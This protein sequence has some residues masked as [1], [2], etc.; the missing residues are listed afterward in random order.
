ML[1]SGRKKNYSD[2][3][4]VTIVGE[5]T[6]VSGEI[7]SQ[8]TVR[9]EGKVSGSINSEDTI[10]IQETGQVSAN[11]VAGQIVIS[12]SVEGNVFAH[13]RLEVT[14]TGKLVGDITAPRLAIAEGVLFEG[15]CTM[16]PPG[17]AKPPTVAAAQSSQSK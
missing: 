13:E 3:K 16:K 11:L 1:D 4:V 14:A 7:V 15:R 12:G 10:V 8:G 9:V 6:E 2:S 5:G 17:E